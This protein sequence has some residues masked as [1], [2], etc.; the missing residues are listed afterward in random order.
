M[1]VKLRALN[2][3]P[4]GPE[5]LA[6]AQSGEGL[7]NAEMQKAKERA[8]AR[9]SLKALGERIHKFRTEKG[10]NRT[11]LAKRAKVTVATIRGCEEGTKVTQEDKLNDIAKALGVSPGRLEIDEKDPRV[12]NW[13]DEDY[14][15]GNWYHNAPR[16]LKNRIWALQQIGEAGKALTDPQFTGLLEGWAKLTQEQKIFVLNSFEYIRKPPN[17]DESM[18]GLNALAAADPKARGPQR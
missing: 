8:S 3:Y 10:W 15:I 7:N 12:R 13:T 2:D 4:L 18:G 16:Q 17:P 1:R 9:K 6:I 5:A 14:E 11:T